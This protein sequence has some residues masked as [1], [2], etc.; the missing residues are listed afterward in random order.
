MSTLPPL[1]PCLF[2]R[3]LKKNNYKDASYFYRSFFSIKN[4]NYYLLLFEEL[5]LRK[6]VTTENEIFFTSKFKF[7]S[8][9]R[10]VK[11]GLKDDFHTV[12]TLCGTVILY[13]K[14]IIGSDKVILELHF[15]KK[16]LVLFRYTFSNMNNRS[17]IENILREKYLNIDSKVCFSECAINDSHGNSIFVDDKVNFSVLYFSF[18][19]EFHDYV[20]NLKKINEEKILAEKLNWK[21]EIMK[22]L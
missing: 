3:F 16:K 9:I 11:S 2:F 6:V 12:K 7:G 18:N 21:A 15:Y 14:T 17:K 4:I 5:K 13:S 10:S 19:F 22:R 8:T 20:I 1:K